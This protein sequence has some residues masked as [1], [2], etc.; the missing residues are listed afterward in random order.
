MT[1]PGV[2]EG[3]PAKAARRIASFKVAGK[4]FLG[5]ETGEATMTV[6]LAEEQARSLSAEDPQAYEE[7]WRGKRLLGLRVQ[8]SKV[9]ATRVRELIRNSRSHTARQRVLDVSKNGQRR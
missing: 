7:I 2:E 6:S 3:P 9:S 8:L 1:L 5:I 4:S